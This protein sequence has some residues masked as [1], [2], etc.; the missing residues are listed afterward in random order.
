ME[1]GGR[2]VHVGTRSRPL[3]CLGVALAP[4]LVTRMLDGLRAGDAVV[5][6]L[7][8]GACDERLLAD[9]A[10]GA[11][12][13][14]LKADVRGTPR[15]GCLRMLVY[16]RGGVVA[17]ELDELE[18]VPCTVRPLADACAAR[19]L[20][21]LLAGKLGARPLDRTGLAGDELASAALA[22]LAAAPVGERLA[23]AIPVLLG[24]GPGLTPSGDDVLL[25]YGVG[26]HL[27]GGGTY[28]DH[29]LTTALHAHPDGGTTVVSRAYLDAY[30]EGYVNPILLELVRAAEA[31]DGGRGHALLERIAAI[32]HT[33]GR[34]TL[35]GLATGL[36][37]CCQGM[38]PANAR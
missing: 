28:F 36:G 22:T 34:D 13:S 37:T 8:G 35:C 38:L 33:S 32:G 14:H 16:A 23:A 24:R 15:A 1:L 20:A 19:W 26:L 21:A 7:R 11:R 30:L 17:L 29:A 10:S 6:R 9:G 25:G 5:L 18:P 12:R 3:S 4:D 27:V 31:H 2:L